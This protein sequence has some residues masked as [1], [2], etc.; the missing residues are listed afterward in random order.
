MSTKL[1]RIKQMYE[2]S[3]K[4]ASVNLGRQINLQSS[5]SSSSDSHNLNESPAKQPS[6]KITKSYR[7]VVEQPK[8]VW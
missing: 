3:S 4:P 5:P 6:I 7:D 2:E 8:M 1:D